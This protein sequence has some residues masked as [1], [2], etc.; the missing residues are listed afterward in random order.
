M[1]IDPLQI[2]KDFPIFKNYPD[3]VYL[4]NAATSQKPLMVI[5]AVSNYYQKY[6]SNIH[7]GIYKLSESS[8]EKYEYAREKVSKFIGCTNFKEIIFTR[9]TNE[10]INLISY[11][12]GKK[13][14][15]EGDIVVLSEMEHHANLVPWIRLKNEMGIILYFI[16]LT[17]DFRLDFTKITDDIENISKIKLVSITHVSNV[18]GTINPVTEIT[19]FLKENNINAKVYIDAAQSVPHLSIN[20]KDLGCD[21]LTFSS[22]KMMGPSGVG[23]LWAK[24]NLLESMDPLLVGSHMILNVSKNDVTFTGI[25][26]KFEAGTANL[27]GVVGLGA[28]IDYLENLG[29]ENVLEHDRDLV[30]YG[31][32]KLS[33]VEGIKIFG[34]KEEKDRL[35]IF[36][37]G[38]EGIHPHDIAQIL[39]EENIAIRSGHHCA[40]ILMESLKVIATARAS[41]YI[42]NSKEDI[43]KLTK[44]LGKVKQVLKC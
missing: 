17:S 23:V 4:D 19:S 3:L 28:A 24:A 34:P 15:K 26:D 30:K 36:S 33:E 5:D 10:A 25:P 13:F 38:F 37:F 2:K 35:A 31:L 1:S 6:N 44:G 42:Y 16:P 18:L 32:D 43:D 29:M 11:G 21:F 7:R 12:W 39:D 40:Q 9:N 22:H 20:I 27:E 14:L 41:C 8:T